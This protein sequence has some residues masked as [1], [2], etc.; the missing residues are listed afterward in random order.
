M[1]EDTS[2]VGVAVTVTV[3]FIAAKMEVALPAASKDATGPS[4]GYPVKEDP[5]RD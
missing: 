1:I 5:Y 3:E 2:T 4:V